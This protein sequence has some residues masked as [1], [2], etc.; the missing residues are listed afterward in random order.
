MIRSYC[1]INLS[2]RVLKR[3]LNGLHDIQTNSILLNLHDEIK[4]KKINKPKDI[5][6]F[7]GKFKNFIKRK[8]NS[9]KDAINTIRESNFLNNKI[10]YRITIKKNIPIFSGLGGGSSNAAF[11]LQF[12]LK[13]KINNS[14][15]KKVESK[16]G[17]DLRL[18]FQ[19]QCFQK[20][21]KK[22]NRYKKN[23][24]LYFILVLPNFK[25]STKEI[26]SKVKSFS[27]P[28]IINYSQ[29][30]SKAK[31]INLIKKERNDLEKIV[32]QKSSMLKKIKKFIS[33]QQDCYFARMTG[34]GSVCFGMFKSQKSAKLGLKSV[35]K[36]F[37]YCWSVATKTI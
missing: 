1:K 26:Y 4:I 8:K 11:I 9:V 15:L 27:Q 2:L 14:F 6:I 28:S 19:K 35:K 29:I 17:T 3:K 21:L 7:K 32:D 5:I 31:F 13:N 10:K 34:S 18:F 25:C 12:F 20:N 22:I 33:L 37:P 16:V 23:H 24:K 30:T 36:K